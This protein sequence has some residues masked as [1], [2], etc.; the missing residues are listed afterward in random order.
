MHREKMSSKSSLH[1]SP[2]AFL[3]VLEESSAI[4]ALAKELSHQWGGQRLMPMSM[5]IQKP[6]EKLVCGFRYTGGKRNGKMGTWLKQE[7]SPWH[8]KSVLFKRA[9]KR[10]ICRWGKMGARVFKCKKKIISNKLQSMIPN[11]VHVSII[12]L[13][14]NFNCS[15]F[16]LPL[17]KG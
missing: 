1:P 6:G 14:N 2:S 17:S 8:F 9:K 7:N 16:H 11:L 3:W 13:Q 5:T 10:N 15:D 12:K 4:S